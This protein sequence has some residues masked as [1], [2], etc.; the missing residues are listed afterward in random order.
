MNYL[1][2]LDAGHGLDTPGKRTPLFP[3]DSFMRENEFNRSVVRKIDSLLEK[4]DIIDTFFS[5]TEKY[6][7][8][9][10][11]R[12]Q[13]ANDIYE[14]NR[15]LYE[16][17]VFISVHANALTGSWGTQNGTSSYHYPTNPVDKKMSETYS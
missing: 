3:D 7:V 9:L 10:A 2:I 11:E 5:V 16:K 8:S 17:V 15:E 1:V 12:V 13:R 14:Q 4:N 6:D